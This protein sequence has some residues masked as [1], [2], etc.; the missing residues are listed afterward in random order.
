MQGIYILTNKINK[1]QYIGLSTCIE[2]RLKQHFSK[3]SKN[4]QLIQSAIQTFG[5][6]NFTIETINCENY[7][8][9]ILACYEKNL[10]KKLNTLSPNGYNQRPGGETIKKPPKQETIYDKIPLFVKEEIYQMR[11]KGV[12]LSKIEREFNLNKEN[13]QR[14]LKEMRLRNY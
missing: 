10:I 4:L 5:K 8:P 13:L 11:K 1:K 12:I 14:V 3:N 9:V 2:K 7:H 6:H